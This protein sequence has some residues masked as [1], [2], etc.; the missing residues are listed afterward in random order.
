MTDVLQIHTTEWNVAALTKSV[1]NLKQH[2]W[3][4]FLTIISEVR[5]PPWEKS[6]ACYICL[7]ETLMSPNPRPWTDRA[8]LRALLFHDLF[9]KL[10][11]TPLHSSK[12]W[13]DS[14]ISSTQS[15]GLMATGFSHTSDTWPKRGHPQI[16]D[17]KMAPNGTHYNDPDGFIG[18]QIS[19]TVKDKDLSVDQLWIYKYWSP[20]LSALSAVA[21]YW[22]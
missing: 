2:V 6:K 12:L 16:P 21:Q 22:S 17:I 14:A 13:L 10:L 11:L 4:P 8:I 20:V 7:A 19:Q 18:V 9:R 1:A 5:E 15:C 3:H